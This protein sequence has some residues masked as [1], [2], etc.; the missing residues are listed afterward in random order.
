LDRWLLKI[1]LDGEWE[2]CAYK[3]RSEALSA[4]LALI[5][6]Y[7]NHI[8]KAILFSPERKDNWRMKTPFPAS[9][10]IQ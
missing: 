9:G 10:L 2:E 6:D 4:F 8:R 3:T 5:G 7:A 1:E